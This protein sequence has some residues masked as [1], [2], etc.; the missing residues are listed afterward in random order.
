MHGSFE[1]DMVGVKGMN[2]QAT[3]APQAQPN[4]AYGVPQPMGHDTP[5]AYYQ[6]SVITL[7]TVRWIVGGVIGAIWSLYAAGWLFLPAKQSDLEALTRVVVAL[8]TAQKESKGAIERLTVAVDNLSN[9]VTRLPSQKN[10]VGV[11]RGK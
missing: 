3:Q 2:G 6:P 9:I 11:L 1:G 4:P 7:A 8:D 10:P 5:L